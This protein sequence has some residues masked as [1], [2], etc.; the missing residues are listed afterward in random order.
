MNTFISRNNTKKPTA[1]LDSE[2]HRYIIKPV[3][4][5]QP[6]SLRTVLRAIKE[7]IPSSWRDMRDFCGCK[8]QSD[9]FR[10]TYSGG[11]K[12]LRAHLEQFITVVGDVAYFYDKDHKPADAVVAAVHPTI[13]NNE[14]DVITVVAKIA[15]LV[16]T[17]VTIGDKLDRPLALTISVPTGYLVNQ[18]RTLIANPGTSIFKRGSAKRLNEFLK[19]LKY[20]STE[21]G[22]QQII[23]SVDDESGTSA[24]I[25]TTSITVN[26]VPGETVSVP[27]LTVPEDVALANEGDTVL[28]AITVTDESEQLLTLRITP[29]DCEIYNIKNYIGYVGDGE[30]YT[31]KGTASSLT[32]SLAN[33]TVRT[34]ST[35]AQIL[36]E[37]VVSGTTRIRNTINLA[38]SNGSSPTVDEAEVDN[39][40]LDE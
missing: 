6:V 31:T 27:V 12:T 20:T 4:G 16:A 40:T 25:V 38:A 23:I 8:K 10:L 19:T 13:T 18:D 15:T 33:V 22:E 17:R 7:T 36:V 5:S 39:A 14:N 26:V 21:F 29:Y 3:D 32:S 34:E 37:L 30:L 11:A 1:T 2:N 9:M 28:P 35:S 24:G